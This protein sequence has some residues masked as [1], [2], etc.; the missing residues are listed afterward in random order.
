MVA[1]AIRRAREGYGL[2]IRELGRRAG[3][4]AAQISRIEAGAVEQPSVDTLI[5]IARALDRNP[6][7]LLVASG[8]IPAAEAQA[9]LAPMFREHAGE[10]YDPDVDSEIV[11]VWSEGWQ[12][13][14]AGARALLAQEEPD[15]EQ[16]RQLAGEVF[17]TAETEETLW[18]DSWLGPLLQTDEDAGLRQLAERWRVLSPQRREKVLDYAQEQVE[19]WRHDHL[20]LLAADEE[21]AD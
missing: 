17:L 3:V 6:K 13:K 7:P 9:I 18:W 12:T 16:L 21:G 8:H 10:T 5:A 4:S 2:S 19:L 1:T 15:P 14:L 20:A 11:D